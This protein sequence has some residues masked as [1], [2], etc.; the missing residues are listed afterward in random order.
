MKLSRF[1][2]FLLLFAIAI[3][4]FV[5][6][7]SNSG[8]NTQTTTATFGFGSQKF[9][10]QLASVFKVQIP[11][12]VYVSGKITM[13][14]APWWLLVLVFMIFY[15]IIDIITGFVPPFSKAAEMGSKGVERSK[16]VFTIGFSLL[17]MFVTPLVPYVVQLVTVGTTFGVWWFWMLLFMM[18]IWGV[19]WLFGESPFGDPFRKGAVGLGHIGSAGMTK[20]KKAFR[21]EMNDTTNEAKYLADLDALM[22]QNIQKNQKER[23]L[24]ENLRQLLNLLVQ[25]RNVNSSAAR[26]ILDKMRTRLLELK[27]FIE[28]EDK[29]N[30]RINNFARTLQKINDKASNV[31]KSFELVNTNIMQ[32]YKSLIS[33][34]RLKMLL[35]EN[36]FLNS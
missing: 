23:D 30:E 28:S 19:N 1:W 5:F 14:V 22:N 20:F 10:S 21:E 24:I 18:F 25:A 7:Q 9:N 16:T 6:S 4:M 8:W 17:A 29:L 26:P 31:T 2:V 15:P 33:A 12:P 36:P 11:F 27:S 35:L 13:V 3:P 32:Y 34:L